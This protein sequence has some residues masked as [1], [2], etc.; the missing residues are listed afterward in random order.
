MNRLLKISTSGMK[1]L[2][3][4]VDISF[5][6][7]TVQNGVKNFTKV[8]AL[9]SGN[10]DGK[11]AVV[12]S[13]WLYKKLCL[14]ENYILSKEAQDFLNKYMNKKTQEYYFTTY[15]EYGNEVLKHS[16]K[17]GKDQFN[18][19]FVLKEERISIINGRTINEDGNVIIEKYYN[20]PIDINPKIELNVDD[21]RNTETR[22][23][24][25][26]FA[27]SVFERENHT[28]KS[29]IEKKILTLYL[30]ILRIHV[31]LNDRELD[32]NVYDEDFVFGLIDNFYSK[33]DAAMMKNSIQNYPIKEDIEK[34]ELEKYKKVNILLADYLHYFNCELINI[35]LDI[36]ENRDLLNIKRTYVYTHW[37][38]EEDY[39]SSGIKQLVRM[40]PVLMSCVRGGIAFM[41]EID[42]NI[43]AHNLLAWLKFYIQE[44]LGQLFFT[45]HNVEI[46]DVLK[47]VPK[48][49]LSIGYKNNIFT[50]TKR[51]NMTPK[52]LF[53]E[54]MFT[55]CAFNTE[56]LEF[57]H[58]FFCEED[59]ICNLFY[60]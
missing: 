23:I 59:Y 18:K 30:N 6:N 54:G 51:G 7:A 57:I 60:V 27:R 48:S 21:F 42:A 20:E 56:D 38:V 11:T 58:P 37:K 36:K 43:N 15:F 52:N 16:I 29:E 17:V 28:V 19:S 13:A 44:G 22:S 40:F 50:W 49:I 2:W 55:D 39:E 25:I 34:K 47:D 33:E 3:N 53:M 1:C 41:D 46:M 10:G 4:N 12:Y 24:I 26:S 8:K 9:F 5:S 32:E 14:E 31:Y 35:E 45:S